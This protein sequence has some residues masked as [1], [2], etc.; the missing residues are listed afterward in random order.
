MAETYGEAQ[1]RGDELAVA[2]RKIGKLGAKEAH[3]ADIYALAGTPEAFKASQ[4]A[5]IEL[6]TYVEEV[7]NM[8]R[9]PESPPQERDDG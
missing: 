3:R 2:L 5:L 7:W 4:E 9:S 8:I 6:N 1:V